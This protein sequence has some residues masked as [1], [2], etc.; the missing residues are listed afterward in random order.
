MILKYEKPIKNNGFWIK[1][2]PIPINP[3]I[4]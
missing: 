2:D 4:Q 1:P 3:L